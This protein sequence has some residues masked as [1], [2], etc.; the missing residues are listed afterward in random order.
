MRLAGTNGFP[1]A[2]GMTGM[3]R[4]LALLNRPHRIPAFAGRGLVRCSMRAYRKH[5]SKL[6]VT[7]DYRVF[8]GRMI[9]WI[10]RFILLTPV[11]TRKVF[12][13]KLPSP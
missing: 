8:V 4:R 1:L 10:I 12:N 2:R 5:Q 3:H 6:Q 11:M 13:A 7:M 9:H